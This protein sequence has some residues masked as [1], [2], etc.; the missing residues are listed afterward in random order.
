EFTAQAGRIG[1]DLAAEGPSSSNSTAF[2]MANYRYSFTGLLSSL[3]VH[4]G[5]ATVSSQDLPCNVSLPAGQAG[6][7]TL[8]GM[9]GTS[10]NVFEAKED[11][12]D[13]EYEKD[14]FDITFKSKMGAAG[15]THRLPLSRKTSLRTTIAASA[16]S[17]QR[18]AFRLDPSN[19]QNVLSSDL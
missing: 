6:E 18:E 11:V 15:I 2:Y 9:G 3:V 4:L 13:W 16:L 14:G 10:K 1:L 7:F 5:G 19:I 8:V 17:S 12:N